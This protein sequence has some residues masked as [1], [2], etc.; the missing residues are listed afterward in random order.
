M[1][2]SSDD[3]CDVLQAGDESGS[4]LDCHVRREVQRAVIRL[5]RLISDFQSANMEDTLP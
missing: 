5:G 2:A 3:L 4:I 1:V